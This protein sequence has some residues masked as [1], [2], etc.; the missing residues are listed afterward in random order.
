MTF[1]LKIHQNSNILG[2]FKA[3]YVWRIPQCFISVQFSR[4]ILVQILVK[5]S[6]Q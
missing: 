1:P 2:V 4:K 5:E 3:F 6:V